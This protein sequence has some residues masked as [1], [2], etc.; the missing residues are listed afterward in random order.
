MSVQFHNLFSLVLKSSGDWLVGDTLS[1]KDHSEVY[2]S[3]FQH[4]LWLEGR[5]WALL[6]YQREQEKKLSQNIQELQDLNAELLGHMDVKLNKEQQLHK[7]SKAFVDEL[8]EK[9]KEMKEQYQQQLKEIE[10]KD[11]QLLLLKKKGSGLQFELQKKQEEFFEK[12]KEFSE[13]YQ[14]KK[15]ELAKTE[16]QLEKKEQKIQEYSHL[17]QL[18]KKEL[19]ECQDALHTQQLKNESQNTQ[20]LHS[21]QGMYCINS[22]CIM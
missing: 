6:K 8:Q 5:E 20:L 21:S 19:E 3:K 17:L 22:T 16:H 11:L 13:L 2:K 12:E 9:K 7:Q 4:R 10:E 14:L 18:N 15:E 1:S